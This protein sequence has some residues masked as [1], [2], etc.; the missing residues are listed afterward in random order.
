MVSV[1][2]TR[3]INFLRNNEST[4]RVFERCPGCTYN[5]YTTIYSF[6]Y[7]IASEIYMYIEKNVAKNYASS[8]Y[9]FS[10]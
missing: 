9:S 3:Q 8:C 1:H 10:Q 6:I 4:S 2:A 5:E 7:A